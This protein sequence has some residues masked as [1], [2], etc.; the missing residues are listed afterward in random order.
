MFVLK[1]GLKRNLQRSKTSKKKALALSHRSTELCQ[2][3][4]SVIPDPPS[5]T[6]PDF[7]LIRIQIFIEYVFFVVATQPSDDSLVF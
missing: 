2:A 6:V 7:V 1:L 3:L 5:D 4:S